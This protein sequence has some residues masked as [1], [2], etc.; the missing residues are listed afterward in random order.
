MFNSVNTFAALG[1]WVVLRCVVLCCIVWFLINDKY[2]VGM[3]IF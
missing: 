3:V 1:D 2:L